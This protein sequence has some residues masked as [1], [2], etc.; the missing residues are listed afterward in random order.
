MRKSR[1][2]PWI[3]LTPLRG[4]RHGERPRLLGRRMIVV[5]GQ[6]RLRALL[7]EGAAAG[8]LVDGAYRDREGDA[9]DL[10]LELRDLFPRLPLAVLRRLESRGKR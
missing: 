9:W 1:Q 10:A 6:R 3:L 8:V 7:A 4:W 2:H 5:H